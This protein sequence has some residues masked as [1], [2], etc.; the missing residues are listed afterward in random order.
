MFSPPEALL[1]YTGS[2]ASNSKF[3]LP[4]ILRRSRFRFPARGKLARRA[5]LILGLILSAAFFCSCGNFFGGST[6]PGGAIPGGSGAGQY[7]NSCFVNPYRYQLRGWGVIRCLD[8]FEE[9][10]F[11]DQVK[12]YLSAIC[13]KG[14]LD[15]IQHVGCLKDDNRGKMV[16]RGRVYF[17]NNSKLS[18]GHPAQDLQI[19]RKSYIEALVIPHPTSL[20]MPVLKLKVHGGRVNGHEDIQIS[21]AGT[22]MKLIL[23]GGIQSGKFTGQFAFENKHSLLDGQS[24]ATGRLGNSFAIQACDFFNCH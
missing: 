17:T 1:A 2:M 18:L 15:K 6:A 9:G 13:H 19:A 16:F 10:Q 23:S 4:F 5:E 3:I 22:K 8:G 11:Q 7:G 14:D 21:F 24:P 20:Y 12:D